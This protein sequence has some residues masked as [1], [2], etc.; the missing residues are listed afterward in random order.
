MSCRNGVNTC[1]GRYVMLHD[2]STLRDESRNAIH[3]TDRQACYTPKTNE[4]KRRAEL[5]RIEMKGPVLMKRWHQRKKP[6]KAVRTVQLLKTRSSIM[7]IRFACRYLGWWLTETR[8][9]RQTNRERSIRWFAKMPYCS[10]VNWLL[11]KILRRWINTENLTI[12]LRTRSPKQKDW[13]K[14]A[15]QWLRFGWNGNP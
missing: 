8:N 1:D 14:P 7:V 15:C 10:I 3:T 12:S 2:D 11:P 6:Y 9:D 4:M 13:K 5:H